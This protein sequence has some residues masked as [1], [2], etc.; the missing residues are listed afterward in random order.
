VK[1]HSTGLIYLS[2]LPFK[3]ARF[4]AFELEKYFGFIGYPHI[5]HTDNGK[6]FVATTVVRLL[7]DNNP[8]C[9]VVTG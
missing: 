4:V 8:H 1:D 3:K 7:Q 6:K 2:S 5:F 9:F